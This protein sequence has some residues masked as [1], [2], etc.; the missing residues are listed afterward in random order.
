MATLMHVL[1]VIAGFASLLSF[2]GAYIIYRNQ[3]LEEAEVEA[4]AD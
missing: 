3:S 2:A 4:S 1:A